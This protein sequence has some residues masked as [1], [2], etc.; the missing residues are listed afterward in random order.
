MQHSL[1]HLGI[2]DRLTFVVVVESYEDAI[3]SLGQAMNT[4]YPFLQF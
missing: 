1:H 4:G 2:Y 3:R